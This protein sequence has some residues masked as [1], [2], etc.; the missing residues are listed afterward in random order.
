[1]R[2]RRD[3]ATIQ[4]PP[5]SSRTAPAT[6]SALDSQASVPIDALKFKDYI[7]PLVVLKRLFDVFDDEVG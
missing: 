4:A 1:L 5:A 7:L 3:S 2:E 6:A